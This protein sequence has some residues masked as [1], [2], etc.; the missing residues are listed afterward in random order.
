MA[1]SSMDS[2]TAQSIQTAFS[3]D[4]REE[5]AAEELLGNLSPRESALT[6]FFASS[7]YNL[8]SL[9]EHLRALSDGAPV[10]G[11]TTAGE[12]APHGYSRNSIT[13]FSLP[14]SRFRSFAKL[15][16]DLDRTDI[17]DIARIGETVQRQVESARQ[18]DPGLKAFAFLLIDGLSVQEERLVGHLHASLKGIPLVGGS[19]GDDLAFERTHVFFEGR[20]LSN[21]AVLA[22]CLTRLPFTAFKT[23]HFEPTEQKLVITDSDPKTRT[24]YEI[25]GLPAAQAYAEL[26]GCNVDELNPSVFSAHPVMLRI[27]GQHFVRSIQ[28]RNPDDS[29]TFYCAIDT[30]L[31][32]SIGRGVDLVDN[33]KAAL[34]RASRQ[35]ISP[36]LIITC[37]CVLRRLEVFEKGLDADVGRILSSHRA[38][39]FHSYGEQFDS[40]HVNQTFSGIAIGQSQ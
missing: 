17:G 2:C 7:R 35:V 8:R 39:G 34:G 36:E 27:G 23:Q 19:A 32:L 29:L 22:V 15:I 25:N 9:E 24:V 40:I 20:F 14:S 3:A 31:V 18:T 6:T 4:V 21:A 10:I 33:L 5:V 13:G 37:E 26:V 38:I 16:P 30:G 11:C 1:K 12:I 28:R